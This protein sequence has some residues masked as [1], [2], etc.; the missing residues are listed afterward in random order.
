MLINGIEDALEIHPEF[1][2]FSESPGKDLLLGY[3]L[4]KVKGED[5]R[6]RLKIFR[7]LGTLKRPRYRAGVWLDETYPSA[8]I[9]DG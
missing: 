3:H 1:G 4:K 7:N 6:G 8:R 2:R 9:P 5:G